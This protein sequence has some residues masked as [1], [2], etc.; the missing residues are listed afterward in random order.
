[1]MTEFV[2]VDDV[3]V[4]VDDEGMMWN[5]GEEKLQALQKR[6]CNLVQKLCRNHVAATIYVGTDP[7]Q[8]P[9]CTLSASICRLV[10][11]WRQALICLWIGFS[12]IF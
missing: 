2:V 12:F 4:V 11:V 6:A 10:P 1:M 9:I 3:A 5:Q 7:S 8:L